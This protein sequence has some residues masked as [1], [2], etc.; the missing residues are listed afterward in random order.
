VIRV[1]DKPME[2]IDVYFRRYTIVVSVR[3]GSGIGS[4]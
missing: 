1:A 4:P 2:P 3:A